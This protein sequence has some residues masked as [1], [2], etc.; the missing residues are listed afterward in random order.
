MRYGIKPHGFGH[1]IYRIQ[2]VFEEK[3]GMLQF[4]CPDT[5]SRRLPVFF[6]K[7]SF[8]SRKASSRDFC[9]VMNGQVFKIE[10]V[11]HIVQVYFFPAEIFQE[12]FTEVSFRIG[13]D[14][15]QQELLGFQPEKVFKVPVFAAEVGQNRLH[16][17]FKRLIGGQLEHPGGRLPGRPFLEDAGILVDKL[18]DEIA[19]DKKHEAFITRIGRLGIQVIS[20]P[21]KE[22]V[23]LFYIKLCLFRPE[24]LVALQDVD[25]RIFF[26]EDLVIKRVEI[27]PEGHESIFPEFQG[28][29]GL[30]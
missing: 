16:K 25:H 7:L 1:L 23:A 4:F 6:R 17:F 21:H 24:D 30:G 14:E 2:L 26:K 15:V 9:K 3:V 10:G 20:F 28:F 5:G 13:V 29:E 19:V 18:A 11:Y 12:E 8:E 22:Q 27:A